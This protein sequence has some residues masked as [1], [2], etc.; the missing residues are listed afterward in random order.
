MYL[1]IKGEEAFNE[2]SICKSGSVS[3]DQ[4]GNNCKVM[5]E[6]SACIK[7]QNNLY[8]YQ[9]AKHIHIHRDSP[10]IFHIYN[11]FFTATDDWTL[12]YVS[13]KQYCMVEIKIGSESPTCFSCIYIKLHH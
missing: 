2:S 4:P 9:E 10:Y 12:K 7:T 8:L 13:M 5:G 6:T 3:N 1:L 11:F